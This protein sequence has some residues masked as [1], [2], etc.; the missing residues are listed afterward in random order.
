[1]TV[2]GNRPRAT[3]GVSRGEGEGCGRKCWAGLNAGGPLSF[4]SKTCASFLIRVADIQGRRIGGKLS[5]LPKG[6]R[7]RILSELTRGRAVGGGGGGG[8]GGWGGGGGG[9]GVGGGGGGGGG[10]QRWLQQGYR[11]SADNQTMT[12]FVTL[13]SCRRWER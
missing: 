1:V 4:K 5:T 12:G 13:I 10:S 11:Q 7:L 2:E 8:G 6:Q 3:G 9:G